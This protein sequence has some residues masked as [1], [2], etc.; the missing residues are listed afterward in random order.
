MKKLLLILVVPLFL[1]ATDNKESHAQKQQGEVVATVG[2]GWGLINALFNVFE[3]VKSVPTINGM[4][5]YGITENF[6][7]GGAVSY[8]R[9]SY[10]ETWVNQETDTAGNTITTEN[11]V[12]A[13]AQRINYAVRPLFHFGEKEELDLYTGAR[14]GFS[15]WNVGTE[16][17]VDGE[18]QEDFSAPGNVFSFQ[19]LFGV[20]AYFND[21]IGANFE[22]GLGSAPYFIHGGLVFSF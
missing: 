12:K 14:L 4:V 13:Y 20:R 8:N 10:Q 16:T 7:L 15:N 9:W 21:F 3:D 11:K 2:A 6:S 1:A 22:V 17:D 18:R 5:D 19:A